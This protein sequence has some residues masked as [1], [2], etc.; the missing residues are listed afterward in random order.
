MSAT[1]VV[2]HFPASQEDTFAVV[3]DLSAYDGLLPAT[4]I[5]ADPLPIHVGWRFAGHTGPRKPGLRALCLVDR[6]RVTEWDPPRGFAVVKEG[7]VL[8]G[9]AQVTLTEAEGGT[10]VTW[11]EE[12]VPRPVVV[13]RKLAPLNAQAT[14]WMFGRALDRMKERVISNHEPGERH[15]DE[16]NG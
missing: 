12:I 16:G 14:H 4:W 10:W 7:P 9:W 8:S 1:E 6:M 11:R 5:A 3:G 15:G 13:G 2:R